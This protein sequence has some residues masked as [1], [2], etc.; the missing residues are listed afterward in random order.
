MRTPSPHVD[1]TALGSA[2]VLVFLLAGVACSAP[3]STVVAAVEASLEAGAL[4]DHVSPNLPPTY[5]PAG[6]AVVFDRRDDGA[7]LGG[8]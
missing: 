8:G 5:L 6:A 4:E 7:T 3:A 2:A 1:S